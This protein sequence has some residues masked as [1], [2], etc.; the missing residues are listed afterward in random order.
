[1]EKLKEKKTAGNIIFI[2]CMFIG[3]GLGM[4]FH[5]TGVGTIIGMG[6]GYILKAIIDNQKKQ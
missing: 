1:M 4:F 3:I 6:V 5:S 2:G